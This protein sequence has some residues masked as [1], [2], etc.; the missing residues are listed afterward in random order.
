MCTNCAIVNSVFD[1]AKID[2]LANLKLVYEL[3][4]TMVESGRLILY[5]G[6]CPFE[7]LWS[8]L[9][10]EE[11][12]TYYSYLQCSN[13]DCG[14]IYELAVCIRSSV[15]ILKKVDNINDINLENILW[16]RAGIYFDK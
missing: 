7:D 1:G 9:D 15:P 8:E 12:F 16:G 2:T 6:D 5:A 3:L 13:Q 10:K 14:E 11:H 4:R